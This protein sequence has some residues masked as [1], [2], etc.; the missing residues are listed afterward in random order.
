MQELNEIGNLEKTEKYTHTVPY[1]E[2]S[3]TRIQPIL[4]KQWF[5]D[6][7]DSAKET[8]SAIDS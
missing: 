8:L 5:V 1:C 4:S 7:S 2:R 3:N 6:V